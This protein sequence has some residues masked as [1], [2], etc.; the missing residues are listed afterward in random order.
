MVMTMTEYEFVLRFQLPTDDDKPESF[1]DAL[2]EAGCDDAVVGVGLAGYLS[3]DFT[4]EAE[5]AKKAVQSAI[6][7]VQ[8]AIPNATLIEVSPDLL[9]TTEIADLC[10]ER[11]QKISRQ[12]IRKYAFGHVAKTFTRFPAPAVTSSSSLWHVDD[13]ISW[14]ITN[15]KITN[16]RHPC[17][18]EKLLE[19]AKTARAL[20]L[21]VQARGIQDDVQALDFLA[22]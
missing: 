1:L 13:V 20:N 16:N 21:R 5:S 22:S 12:A 19:I 11:V 18:A 4:R 3:L 2:Y 7:N 14:M 15:K 6:N 8:K 10:S 17:S 9:N